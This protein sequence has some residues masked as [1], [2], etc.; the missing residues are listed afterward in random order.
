MANAVAKLST[1]AR[2]AFC[3][4]GQPEAAHII[5]AARGNKYFRAGILARDF[6]GLP[7]WES[8]AEVTEALGAAS[9]ALW[10]PADAHALFDGKKLAIVPVSCQR[11][12]T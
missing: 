4:V 8:T 9:N 10:L 1:A 3:N 2:R 11:R 7:E 6:V 12:A 5:H